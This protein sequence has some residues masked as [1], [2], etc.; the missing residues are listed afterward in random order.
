[1][2]AQE[3]IKKAETGKKYDGQQNLTTLNTGL[4][5]ISQPFKINNIC[6]RILFLLISWEIW[7]ERNAHVF[8]DVFFL[9]WQ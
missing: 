3:E 5:Q 8:W 6:V 2:H 4:S 9:Y 7:K 1:L